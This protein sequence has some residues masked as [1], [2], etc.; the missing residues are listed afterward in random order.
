MLFHPK[1]LLFKCMIY[2][3]SFPKCRHS[4]LPLLAKPTKKAAKKPFGKGFKPRTYLHATS[5]LSRLNGIRIS[6]AR[7]T[8]LHATG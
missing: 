3:L 6:S 4:V 7:D 8:Y 5:C 1:A 2:V